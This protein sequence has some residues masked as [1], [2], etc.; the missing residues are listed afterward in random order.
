MRDQMDATVASDILD[1]AGYSVTIFHTSG[2][3]RVYREEPEAMGGVFTEEVWLFD[4]KVACRE[5]HRLCKRL[6]CDER[7]YRLTR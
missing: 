1:R 5:V 2:I 7:G 3:L 6:G 4:G